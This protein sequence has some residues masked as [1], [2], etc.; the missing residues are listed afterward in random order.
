[1]Q[2]F[3]AERLPIL[4]MNEFLALTGLAAN[5][6]EAFKNLTIQRM[7]HNPVGIAEAQAA[8]ERLIA[9]VRDGQDRLTNL[10]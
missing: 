2:A 6:P 5:A 7:T 1:M 3:P 4:A 9:L 10:L 8:V